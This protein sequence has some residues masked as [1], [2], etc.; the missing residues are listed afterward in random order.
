MIRLQIEERLRKGTTEFH[1]DGDLDMSTCPLLRE[2]LYRHIQESAVPAVLV[3]FSG[4]DYVDATGLGV[5]IT[6]WKRARE[7]NGSLA[8]VSPHPRILQLLTQVGLSRVL[9]LYATREAAGL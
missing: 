7:K 8:L 3:D 1:L 6:A 2:Q 9:P 5:L 4:V